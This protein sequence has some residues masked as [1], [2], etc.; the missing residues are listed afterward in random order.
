MMIFIINYPW[1]HFKFPFNLFRNNKMAD[2][3]LL[4]GSCGIIVII[5]AKEGKGDEGIGKCGQEF[6]STC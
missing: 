6:L 5:V 3:G 2:N 1:K 4:V